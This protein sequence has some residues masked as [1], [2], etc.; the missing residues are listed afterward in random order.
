MKRYVILSRLYD[1]IWKKGFQI[2]YLQFEKFESFPYLEGLRTA[3]KVGNPS[4]V[5]LT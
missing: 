2:Q 4:K 1:F 5:I 3:V